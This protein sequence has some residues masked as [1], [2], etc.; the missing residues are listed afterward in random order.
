MYQGQFRFRVPETNLDD[1]LIV[2]Y[3]G[4]KRYAEPISKLVN[5]VSLDINLVSQITTLKEVIVRSDFWRKQYPPEQLKEDYTKFYTIMEKVHTGL[6][7]YITEGEWQVLKDSS[8]QLFTYPMSHSEFYRLIAFHVGKVRDMH[9]RH[10]VTDWWYKQ[11]QNIFPFNVKYF[12]DRLYVSEPLVKE[13][14]FERGCEIVRINGRT[15]REIR[16]MIWPF[17][18]AD[19]FNKTGK[20]ASLNDYFPWYFSLFVE[21]AEQYDIELEK[22]GR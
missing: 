7:E 17:I 20:M 11:K 4:Y 6:F 1:S 5:K 9:T 18:P 2:T 14:E 21:E 22:V 13:L 3:V 16:D 10:G 12:G 19:G 15:P 8:L